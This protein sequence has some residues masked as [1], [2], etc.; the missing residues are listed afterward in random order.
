MRRLY[1]VK[2][3]VSRSLFCKIWQIKVALFS[4]WISNIDR[5]K[6]FFQP[7]VITGNSSRSLDSLRH[8]LRLSNLESQQISSLIL[9]IGSLF[10]CDHFLLKYLTPI[11][12][13]SP[14]N[15]MQIPN[16]QGDKFSY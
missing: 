11:I 1:H 5:S 10:K 12:N 13:R 2:Y 8:S 4:H 3:S 9:P 14:N 15:T 7:G 6:N 16:S